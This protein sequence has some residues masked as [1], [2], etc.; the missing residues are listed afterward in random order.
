MES[1]TTVHIF[2][3]KYP[4]KKYNEPTH[5][6]DPW[7][8]KIRRSSQKLPKTDCGGYRPSRLGKNAIRVSR[9]RRQTWPQVDR[10][11]YIYN[12]AC[13]CR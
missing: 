12:T 8:I 13:V 6:K 10:Q 11:N 5:P 4:G 3:I 1:P 7:S 9:G 2:K